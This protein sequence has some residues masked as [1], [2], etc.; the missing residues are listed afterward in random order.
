MFK[1]LSKASHKEHSFS[2]EHSFSHFL[3][4]AFVRKKRDDVRVEELGM[5]SQEEAYRVTDEQ[6]PINSYICEGGEC[7]ALSTVSLSNF[8]LPLSRHSSP[9]SCTSDA[10][11]RAQPY[12]L[13]REEG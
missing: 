3:T 6:N 7:L 5:Y 1:V 2:R 11:A 13:W 8:L 4:P 9:C 10:W 12:I